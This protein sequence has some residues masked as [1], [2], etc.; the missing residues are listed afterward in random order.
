MVNLTVV[1]EYIKT[2]LEPGI[3]NLMWT[4][5][6]LINRLRASNLRLNPANKTTEIKCRVG[7]NQGLSNARVIPKSG[8]TKT[9]TQTIALA[10]GKAFVEIDGDAVVFAPDNQEAA[11]M[12]AVAGETASLLDSINRNFEI[13]LQGKGDGIRG[14]VNGAPSLVSG[15]TYDITLTTDNFDWFEVGMIIDTYTTGSTTLTGRYEITLTDSSTSVVR[16]TLLSGAGAATTDDVSNQLEAGTTGSPFMGILGIVD[17]GT[18]LITLQ[19]INSS[20]YEL[21][22]ARVDENGGTLRTLTKRMIDDSIIWCN[23][24]GGCDLITTTETLMWGMANLLESQ[25]QWTNVTEL[26]GGFTGMK[27]SGR[28][29]HANM[30]H[31]AHHIEFLNSQHLEIRQMVQTANSLFGAMQW[32]KMGMGSD[33]FIADLTEG[34]VELFKGLI[35]WD[36]ELVT[37]NRK[38]HAS[39][40]DVQP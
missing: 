22:R 39:V 14:V 36:F 2:K 20:D 12:G 33:Y 35:R 15:T 26:E 11:F 10:S 18:E 7:A 23:R 1:N 19:G 16:A 3:N 8:K 29:I 21:W 28:D 38:A 34:Q 27:W 13:T 9:I 5:N 4:F 37:P 31:R 6:F 30:Y 32:M 17:D 40:R 24:S 25:R